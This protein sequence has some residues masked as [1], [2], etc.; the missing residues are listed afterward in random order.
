MVQQI[1]KDVDQ[2]DHRE[3]F[4]GF[5][6][7]NKHSVNVGASQLAQHLWEEVINIQCTNTQHFL[8]TLSSVS[9]G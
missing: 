4:L 8:H 9:F 5:G 1:F 7:H 3:N 6:I 2:T